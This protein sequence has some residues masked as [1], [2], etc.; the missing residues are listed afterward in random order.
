MINIKISYNNLDPSKYGHMVKIH[1][2]HHSCIHFSVFFFF[3]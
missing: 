3:C 2:N 1:F